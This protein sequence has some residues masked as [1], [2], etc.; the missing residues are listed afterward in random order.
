MPELSFSNREGLREEKPLIFDDAPESLR[1]GL[2]EVLQDLGIRKPKEQRDIISKAWRCAHDPENWGDDYISDEVVS[3][4]GRGAWYKFY[5]RIERVPKYLLPYKIA[6]YHQRVND[7]LADEGIGYRFHGGKL[8]RV[9]TEEFDE[10]VLVARTAL[11][12]ER[13]V[14]PRK[15]FERGLEF[16]NSRPPDWANAIKEAANSV[17][18]VLQVIY[19]R[20]GVPLTTIVSADLPSDLPKRIKDLF[21]SLYGLGSGTTGARHGAVEGIQPSPAR[22]EL[23]LHVAAALHA[24]AVAE[25]DT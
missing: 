11:T 16:R 1:Y 20:P 12:D 22:A 9:G 17:E 24:F 6:E 21:K 3:L 10:V 7:L 5:D 25:L 13:F 4:L 8:V 15:Q 14:E 19:K 18:A 2:R 23:A